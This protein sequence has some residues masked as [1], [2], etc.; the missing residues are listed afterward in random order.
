MR[1]L[2]RVME[3]Y[4]V[5]LV[6]LFMLLPLRGTLAFLPGLNERRGFS[7]GNW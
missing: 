2:L 5:S 3:S 4:F 1:E 6:E 7:K